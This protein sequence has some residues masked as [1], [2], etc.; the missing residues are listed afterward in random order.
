LRKRFLTG[1]PVDAKS[2]EVYSTHIVRTSET[3]KA[4]ILG[5][6]HG[7]SHDLSKLTEDAE[8][9]IECSC[10]TGNEASYSCVE[11]CIGIKEPDR[12]KGDLPDIHVANRDSLEVC[13]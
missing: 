9:S 10:R 5:V 2:I 1:R 3:A 6:V 7:D 11:R 8:N 4:I 12:W 13:L